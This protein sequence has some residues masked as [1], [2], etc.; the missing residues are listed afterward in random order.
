MIFFQNYI[1]QFSQSSEPKKK[2]LG[3]VLAKTRSAYDVFQGADPRGAFTKLVERYNWFG[4]QDTKATYDI[5]QNLARNL[6][7]AM[8]Q[9]FLLHFAILLCKEHPTLEAFTE[10]RVPFGSYPLWHLGRVKW[11]SPS[12][13]SDIAIGY[14]TVDGSP[15]Q[16]IVEWP[17][18]PHYKLKKGEGIIPLV[19]INTKIRVSQSE[20]F[21]WHG[22]EQLMTKGNPHC[23]SIQVVLRKE[24][25]LSIVEAAQAGD[26]FFLLGSGGERDVVPR[27]QELVRLA[28][29]IAD[30][31]ENRMSREI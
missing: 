7:G 29:T 1:E 8:L 28:E 11:E 24:M 2:E 14:L 22:R 18:Q 23:L 9:D 17:K 4:L 25:D 27:P 3:A 30:H 21:D 5:T 31:L 19:T 12:E 20:F 15:I 6:P 26:K 10:V 13:Y 16:N